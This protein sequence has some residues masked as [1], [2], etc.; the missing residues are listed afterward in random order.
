MKTSAGVQVNTVF[1]I[2]T[3]LLNILQTEKP[4]ALLFCFDEGEETFRHAAY[5]E[6]K[7]GRAETPDDFYE[8][9]PLALKLIDSF[10]LKRTSLRSHEADDLLCAYGRKAA[11]DGM[12]VTII[13]GDRDAF[14]LASDVIRIAVPSKGYR[15]PEYFGPGEVMKKFGV[16]PDQIPSYKGLVGDSSDNL[17]GVRGIGPK[18]AEELLQKYDSLEG[19]YDHMEEIRPALRTKLE[20]GREQAFFC[21]KMA[22]LVCDFAL[23]IPIAELAVASLPLTGILAFCK[24][25]EFGL[26]ARRLRS[27]ALTEYGRAHFTP[28]ENG[29]DASVLRSDTKSESPQLSLL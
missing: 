18:A 5:A 14:Q 29:E 2:G 1:G 26:L 13:T 12:R 3:M 4:D 15:E 8:Q 7:A 24:E 19:I 17:P 20:T 27:V 9:I 21:E 22:R 10:S 23:P 28:E 11:E 16:R 6:Y 25:V